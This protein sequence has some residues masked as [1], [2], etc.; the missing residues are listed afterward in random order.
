MEHA[1]RFDFA[2]LVNERF[3]AHFEGMKVA[4]AAGLR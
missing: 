1:D 4:V 3:P 2:A